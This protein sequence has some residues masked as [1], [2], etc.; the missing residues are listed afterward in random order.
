M[1][2]LLLMMACE[3]DPTLIG[4]WEIAAMRAGSTDDSL[5]EVTL[6]G[7]MEFTADSD[8]WAMFAYEW[9]GTW[10]PEPQPVVLV[11]ETDAGENDDFI[12]SYKKR[13][14]TYT[15]NLWLTSGAQSQNTFDLVD[16]KGSTVTLAGESVMPPGEWEHEGSRMIWELDLER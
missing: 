15:L 3:R 8:C 12:D 16:W 9:S 1:L 2:A 6:A 13:G 7:S 14:E 10:Q 5:D 4:Y 11:L